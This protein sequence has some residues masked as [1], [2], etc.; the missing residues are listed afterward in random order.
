MR[1]PS[2][3][4]IIKMNVFLYTYFKEN[5]INPFDDF[6][7]SGKNVGNIYMNA[8]MSWITK[9]EP[10]DSF[11]SLS[12]EDHNTL[13]DNLLKSNETKENKFKDFKLRDILFKDYVV[14]NKNI[15]NYIEENDINTGMPFYYSLD[16]VN[17][18]KLTAHILSMY[19]IYI[20]FYEPSE[21]FFNTSLDDIKDMTD[22]LLI[23]KKTKQEQT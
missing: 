16:N 3:D 6:L 21:E 5:Q 18:V 10:S 15:R 17:W 2:V 7:E 9:N 1:N 23:K 8:A 13:S 4:D 22:I 19:S 12:V 20:N 11:F 14:V